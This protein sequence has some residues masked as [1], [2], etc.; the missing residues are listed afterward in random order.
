[1]AKALDEL[2]EE[3][4]G[5]LVEMEGL[6]VEME[7]LLLRERALRARIQVVEAEFKA[8][9]PHKNSTLKSSYHSGNCD[10]YWNECDRCGESSPIAI[11]AHSYYG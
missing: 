1:M 8:D 3:L 11:K 6:L 10:A 7:G 4:K 5:L 2:E 9:C